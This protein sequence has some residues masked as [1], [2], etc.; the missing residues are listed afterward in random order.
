MKGFNNMGNTCYLN[1]GLQMIIQNVDLCRLI[2]NYS[3]QSI[4][5]NK[6]SFLIS[7]YY[8]EN[9]GS[10]TPNQIKQIVEEKQ[11]IFNGCEQQDSTEFVICLL[12][13]IDDEIKKINVNSKGIDDIFGI[14]LNVRI[15]CKYNNCLKIYNNKEKNNF[16]ILDIDQNCSSLDDLYRKFKSSDNLVEDNQYFC[17]NCK[18]KRNASKRYQVIDW[19]N[20]LFINLKR[21]RQIGNN[22]SKQPQPIQINLSWRHDMNLMGAIIHYG[23]INYG[24][25][26][27][28]GKQ[29]DDNWY[30]FNDASIS[31]I[32]NENELTGILNNAY[33]LIYKKLIMTNI[34]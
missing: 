34:K 27:Y 31:L 7:E 11:N 6:I 25:Y 1:A 16:L 19:P 23:N 26:V 12:N 5:L 13:I 8:D 24:H 3:Q 21:F 15:K 22:F 2:L 4:I 29:S 33:W 18:T 28:V 32:K 14:N 9:S 30:L 10:I 20:Y 17:E